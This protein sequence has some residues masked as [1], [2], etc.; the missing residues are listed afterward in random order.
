MANFGSF[1]MGIPFVIAVTMT[2]G[3]MSAHT[4]TKRDKSPIPSDKKSGTPMANTIKRKKKK[5][6][7][8]KKDIQEKFF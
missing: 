1:A 3:G 6:S 5:L 2:S 4:A 7:Y 8:Y